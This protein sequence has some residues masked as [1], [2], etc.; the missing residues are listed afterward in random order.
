MT[1]CPRES[2]PYLVVGHED[3]RRDFKPPSIDNGPEPRPRSIKKSI[4]ETTT[5]NL[6]VASPLAVRTTAQCA[7][8]TNP[9]VLA[10]VVPGLFLFF[11]VPS[12]SVPRIQISI[13]ETHKYGDARIRS[14]LAGCPPKVA[15]VNGR[16]DSVS[17][18]S[19][20]P[21][22]PDVLHV[23]QKVS[24][25]HDPRIVVPFFSRPSVT[26]CTTRFLQFVGRR[27]CSLPPVSGARLV[28]CSGGG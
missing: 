25:F 12:S 5:P 3:E 23:Q 1:S 4:A 11:F 20:Q 15:A 26:S 9:A 18:C 14:L 19:V 27:V 13:V 6:A 16:R 8:G 21:A 7:A 10:V 24:I 28:T 2:S 22:S 17:R